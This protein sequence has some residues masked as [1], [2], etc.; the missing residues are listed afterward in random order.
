MNIPFNPNNNKSIEEKIS[1]CENEIEK[2]ISHINNQINFINR[3]LDAQISQFRD[4]DN[5]ITDTAISNIE[6]RVNT[7]SDDPVLEFIE[8]YISQKDNISDLDTQKSKMELTKQY[9]QFFKDLVSELET[10]V[11]NLKEKKGKV[12]QI[13][14]NKK[15]KENE[16]ESFDE[17]DFDLPEIEGQIDN[18][19]NELEEEK[20]DKDNENNKYHSMMNIE[21]FVMFIVMELKKRNDLNY[22]VEDYQV[23]QNTYP[24]KTSII[25]ENIAGDNLTYLCRDV[26]SLPPLTISQTKNLNM[27][28]EMIN[29]NNLN[30]IDKYTD[31]IISK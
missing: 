30:N 18:L 2:E 13:Q 7:Q 29:D 4:F 1:N 9:E 15:M 12:E 20:I 26:D 8:E 25:K 31:E 24:Q 23:Y 6:R 16:N 19:I 21:E 28:K 11:Q 27:I 17:N 3:I 10:Y 22:N 14:Y 5:H